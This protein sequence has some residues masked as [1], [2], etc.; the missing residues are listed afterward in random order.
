[1]VDVN[2]RREGQVPVAELVGEFT[3]Q[4]A[5][6][7]AENLA[8]IVAGEGAR[9]AIDLSGVKLLDSAGLATLIHWVTR[10]RLSGGR[11]VLAAPSP[12]VRGVLNITRLDGWFDIG[13]DVKE[14]ERMLTES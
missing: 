11:V 7:V 2:I 6:I 8:E 9:L 13:K 4:D 3:S 10:A 5:P 1:M 12:F 14:A